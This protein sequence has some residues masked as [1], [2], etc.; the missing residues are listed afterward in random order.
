MIPG[1]IAQVE[2]GVNHGASNS[3][4]AGRLWGST[5]TGIAT[6]FVGSN[7]MIEDGLLSQ[8]YLK[9]FSLLVAMIAQSQRCPSSEVHMSQ[10]VNKWR[11]A[12][13]ASS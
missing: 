3:T 10:A 8:R 2:A 4:N 13:F 11:K 7:T 5:G 6:Y 1:M 12:E 9:S